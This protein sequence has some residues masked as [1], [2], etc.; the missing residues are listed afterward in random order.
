MKTSDLEYYKPVKSNRK[1]KKFMVRVYL[2]KVKR[3][4]IVHFGNINYQDFTQHKDPERKKNYLRR[5]AFI[6]KAGKLSKSDYTSP[7]FWSRRY[8][9]ASKERYGRLPRPK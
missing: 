5:S 6:K 4:K 1:G 7:N 9:W 2:P 8:L 3:D